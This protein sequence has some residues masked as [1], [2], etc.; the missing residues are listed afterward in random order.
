MRLAR[1]VLCS[2]AASLFMLAIPAGNPVNMSGSPAQAATDVSISIG[3]FYDDLAPYG[4]WTQYEGAYVFIPARVG[5]SWRPYTVGHW[6]YTRQYGW[7][8]VSDEPF[9]W[10]AYHY[11]RWGYDDDIGWYWIPGR[12]WAPAWVSWRRSDDYVVWAPLPP[13]VGDD[14]PEAFAVSAIPERYWIAVPAR[15]FLV[16]DLSA[17]AIDDDRER[18]RVVAAAQPVGNVMIEN[19]V[20]V[21]KAIDVDY[22]RRETKQEVKTVEVKE[23]DDPRQSG[24]GGDGRI[25]AFTGEVSEK[26]GA[27]PAEVKDVQEVKKKKAAQPGA[28]AP[29]EEAQPQPDQARQ[30]KARAGEEPQPGKKKKPSESAAQPAT[31]GEQPVKKKKSSAAASQGAQPATAGEEQPPVKK[32]KR[33]ERAAPPQEAQPGMAGEDQ[34]PVKRKKKAA[35]E[36]R[37]NMEQPQGAQRPERIEKPRMKGSK[38]QGQAPKGGCDPVTG[39]GCAQ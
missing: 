22:V 3:T 36:P 19:N 29:A 26:P 25:S 30:G 39:E 28:T 12:R 5:A 24:K 35:Q 34:Q 33:A 38:P 8:W 20:V 7:L 13:D 9:G 32:K 15:S 27:R 23:T 6:V 2:A 10:A 1:I 14:I 11:G 16:T 31:G 17:V 37:V 4:S 18:V 21:N